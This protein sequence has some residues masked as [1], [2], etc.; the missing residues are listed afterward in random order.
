MKG[1]T[2]AYAR[3]EPTITD[4]PIPTMINGIL[5]SW[6]AAQKR[7]NIV[8][9]NIELLNTAAISSNTGLF[10]MPAGARPTKNIAGVFSVLS[11]SK[12][13]MP[14]VIEGGTGLVRS[15]WAFEGGNYYYEVNIAYPVD[16]GGRKL[17][18]LR[19][20]F[21]RRGA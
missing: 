9:L 19:R 2:N 17:S 18:R 16:G 1:A 8:Y 6:W 21:R 10:T 13:D 3:S 11:S 15:P 12:S 14:L 20:L 7:D 4:I 5:A